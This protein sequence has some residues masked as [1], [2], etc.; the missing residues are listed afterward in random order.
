MM[1]CP[2]GWT[3]PASQDKAYAYLDQKSAELQAGQILNGWSYIISGGIVL[4]LSIPGYFLSDEIFS[5]AIYSLGQTLGVASLGFGFYQL[6]IDDE[7][8]RFHRLLKETPG[9]SAQNRNALAQRFISSL[10]EQ[11]RRGRSVRALSH[12]LTAGLNV[13][14]AFTTDAKDLRVALL[15]IGSINAL[16]GVHAM[17]SETEEEKL[18]RVLVMGDARTYYA[19]LS[20]LF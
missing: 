20:I 3:A 18:A 4:G 11:A 6:W 14:N 5:K 17:V 12:T 1:A 10:G 9:L 16:A 13:M 19:Q 8:I 7:L 2:D 15:F